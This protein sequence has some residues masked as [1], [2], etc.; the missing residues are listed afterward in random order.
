MRVGPL[1]EASGFNEGMIAG[2]EAELCVRLRRAGGRIVRL[3]REMTLHDA[4]MKTFGQWW[5]RSLRTGHAYAEGADL[6]GRTPE[7]H[8]VRPTRRNWF[9]GL[10]LP[11]VAL[12]AAWPREAGASRSSGSIPS[13]W[14]ASPSLAVD[15]ARRSASPFSTGSSSRSESFRSRWASSGTGTTSCGADAL[16]SSSTKTTVPRRRALLPDEPFCLL[17]P[18]AC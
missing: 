4:N 12:A 14:F 10:G 5:K 11:L 13:R 18:S 15:A 17:S 2:E 9:W 3:D 16:G 8:N 1:R 7:R 6:Q